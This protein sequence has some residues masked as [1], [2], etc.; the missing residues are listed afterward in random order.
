MA[1]AAERV[2]QKAAECLRNGAASWNRDVLYNSGVESWMMSE[3]QAIVLGANKNQSLLEEVAEESG[4]RQTLAADVDESLLQVLL[5]QCLL[6]SRRIRGEGSL[7]EIVKEWKARLQK[8]LADRRKSGTAAKFE[9]KIHLPRY[10]RVNTLRVSRDEAIAHFVEN[11][12]TL[13]SNPVPAKWSFSEDPV[14]ANVLRF[15]PQSQFFDDALVKNGSLI[16][17]DRSSCIPAAALAPPLGAHVIDCCAAPGNKT[18]HVAALL[19][20]TGK[21]FAFDRNPKRS[22]TLSRQMEKFGVENIEVFT[23]D[24]MEVSPSDS[25]YAQVTH[26]LCDPTCSGSG[27]LASQVAGGPAE[28]E[29]SGWLSTADLEALAESQVSIVLHAMSFPACKVVTYSTC[30]IHEVENEA[31]VAKILARCPGFRAVECLPG[32]QS[33]G[34]PTHG[35]AGPLCCR[36]SHDVDMTNGFFCARFEKV[37]TPRKNKRSKDEKDPKLQ[38]SEDSVATKKKKKKRAPVSTVPDPEFAVVRKKRRKKKKQERQLETNEPLQP[39]GLASATKKKK[40]R[41]SPASTAEDKE[42]GV[43]SNM[44][45]SKKR[46][47]G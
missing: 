17:Q 16:L 19:A 11:E 8:T 4:L 18:S 34:R 31:V 5:Y 35:P 9:Q 40:K 20:K 43:V 12:W 46:K 7:F 36:A 47:R 44:T 24:F 23:Q 1:K 29:Q 32:W 33:R 39:S 38:P 10:L 15:P 45:P 41:R 2:C 14:I 25:R 13:S 27:Q 6:G 3:V 28:E 30:S 26:F 21:V 37:G 42:I 22:E